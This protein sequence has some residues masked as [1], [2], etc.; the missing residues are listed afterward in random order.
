MNRQTRI[1]VICRVWLAGMETHAHRDTA[2]FG[3]VVRVER[4][5]RS[6]RRRYTV[7][8]TLKRDEE[9][10]PLRVDFDAAK[11]GEREAQK[12]SMLGQHAPVIVLQTFHKLR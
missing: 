12:V 6:H 10:V 1:A 7:A 8:S 11:L 3:P 9:S 4:A 2:S 5:L